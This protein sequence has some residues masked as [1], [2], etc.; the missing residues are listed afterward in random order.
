MNKNLLKEMTLEELQLER[1]KQAELNTKTYGK[2]FNEIAAK[3]DV[4]DMYI[5]KWK[6]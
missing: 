5:E 1:K 4:I 3:I 2:H 6:E